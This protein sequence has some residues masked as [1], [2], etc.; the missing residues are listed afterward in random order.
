MASCAGEYISF[1][2]KEGKVYVMG[3]TNVVGVNN[4]KAKTKNDI[5]ELSLSH[6]VKVSSGINFS[7]AL[8]D[9]GKVY[10]WGNNGN[11]QLGDGGLKNSNEPILV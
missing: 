11:G 1:V 7:M 9:E 10:V 8:D 2:N 3:D 5:V 4:S 6:I